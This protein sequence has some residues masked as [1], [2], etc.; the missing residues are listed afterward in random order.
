MQNNT[1]T[2][3]PLTRLLKISEAALYLAVSERSVWFLIKD[4][5]LPSIHWGR[6]RRIDRDD[7][8]AFIQR[9]KTGGGQ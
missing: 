9:Q 2:T 5:R 3:T 4:G 1:E 6:T 8:D 7:I